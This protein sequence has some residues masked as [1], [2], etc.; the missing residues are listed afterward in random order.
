LPQPVWDFFD[1]HFTYGLMPDSHLI[2]YP[3]PTV[4][5]EVEV[6]GRSINFQWYWNIAEGAPLDDILTDR[7]RVRRPVSVH[8]DDVQPRWLEELRRR[9]REQIGLAAFSELV[10]RNAK[11]FVTIIADTDVPQMALGRICLI[12]DAAVTGRPHAAAGAAKA[13]ANAWALADAL[14][15][16]GGDV[17][18][19]LRRWEPRQL[20]QGR[21]LLRKVRHMAG[22]LQN[23]GA[24]NPAD[25]ACRFGLPRLD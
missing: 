18:E 6:T 16:S 25:S 14:L 24:F 20:E 7:H 10:A 21:A 19:A 3:I 22:L 2:A 1:G 23:G 15:A 17:L 8:A 9:A 4:S 5:D 11:P 13:A 12:G